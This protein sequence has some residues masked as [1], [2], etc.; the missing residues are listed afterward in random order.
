MRMTRAQAA[1]QPAADT[2]ASD[3]TSEAD[4]SIATPSDESSLPERS[5][6]ADRSANGNAVAGDSTT[7]ASKV[8]KQANGAEQEDKAEDEEGENQGRHIYHQSNHNPSLTPSA[9]CRE[10]Q[11]GW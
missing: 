11:A 6:L 7:D 8:E 1:A 2:A 3:Q 5:P 10:R 4:N 9:M